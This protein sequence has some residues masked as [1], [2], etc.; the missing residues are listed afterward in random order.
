MR[1]VAEIAG[2]VPALQSYW[3]NIHPMVLMSSN[4]DKV[5]FCLS[6]QLDQLGFWPAPGSSHTGMNFEIAQDCLTTLAKISLQD[7]LNF[8]RIV[9]KKRIL[10]DT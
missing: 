7:L 3:I 9:R 6:G 4:N 8:G 5:R 2:L 10:A 1:G